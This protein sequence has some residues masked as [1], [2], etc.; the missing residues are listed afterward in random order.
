MKPEMSRLQL[1]LGKIRDER[2]AGN[3][4]ALA[5]AIDKDGSY[6][7]RLFYPEGKAGRKGIGLE[8]MQACSKAFSLAPGFWDMEPDQASTAPFDQEAAEKNNPTVKESKFKGFDANAKIVPNGMRLYPVLSAIQAG[9]VKEIAV[10]Y[11]P[12]DGYDVDYG[13]DCHSDGSYF[14][15]IEGESMLPEFRDGDR[16]LIDPNVTPLAGDF[17]AAKNGKEE[18]TFKKY[19]A[20]G[21]DWRNHPI[22]ELVPLNDDYE[23]IRS[24]QHDLTIL[25]TMVEHHIRRR[26]HRK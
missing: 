22:F 8:I 25:G 26:R 19:R 14:F 24:D 11:E 12:G 6:V 9:K 23:T 7:A 10:P 4:A 1:L 21:V 16:V 2:C 5:R 15:L 17:V 18:A 3:S 20:R 13:D